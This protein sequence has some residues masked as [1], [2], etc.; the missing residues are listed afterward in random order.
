MTPE[1]CPN[2]GADVPRKATACPECGA[3]EETGWSEDAQ[4]A[5][6]GVPDDKFNYNDFV[7]REF[8]K[9]RNL[10][11]GKGWVWWIVSLGTTGVLVW[12]L[13]R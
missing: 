3:C 11:S 12:I 2:C 13:L 9:K 6:L 5:D 4:A 10:P 8:G 7:A 1:S